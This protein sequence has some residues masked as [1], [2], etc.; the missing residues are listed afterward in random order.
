MQASSF[1]TKPRI[2]L[3]LWK[4]NDDLR[5]YSTI[6]KQIFIFVFRR[7]NHGLGNRLRAYASA[8][9]LAKKS[10]RHLIIV[11]I[12]DMHVDS[13]FCDLFDMDMHTDFDQ[14]VLPALQRPDPR[15]DR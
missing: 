6:F 12:P 4:T 9:A 3:S 2:K 10:G 15:A 7:T 8:A 11:W 1:K 13:H 14:P 5:S